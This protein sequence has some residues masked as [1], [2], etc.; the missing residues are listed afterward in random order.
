[1]TE[2]FVTRKVFAQLADMSVDD[3]IGFTE[4]ETGDKDLPLSIQLSDEICDRLANMYES[5]TDSTFDEPYWQFNTALELLIK[6]SNKTKL[7]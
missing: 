6:D 4:R 7:N 1:M 2:V 5:E 3:G